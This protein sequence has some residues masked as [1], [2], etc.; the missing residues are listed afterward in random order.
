[1]KVTLGTFARSGIEAELG[2]D[3]AVTVHAA[4]CHYTGKLQAGRPPIAAPRFDGSGLQRSGEEVLELS[5]DPEVEALLER[6]AARQGIDLDA[7]AA[8]SV[9][10]YLAELDFLR[11][12]TRL[13]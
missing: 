6:E 8:H 4:L 11:A 10:V 3:L 9:L 13:V 1:M 7:L 2:A 12:P 5:V